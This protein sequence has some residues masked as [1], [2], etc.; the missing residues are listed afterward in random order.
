MSYFVTTLNS[1][2]NFLNFK[3]FLPQYWY[4]DLFSN[5]PANKYQQTISHIN[6]Y[7]YALM[8]IIKNGKLCYTTNLSFL[9]FRI[10]FILHSHNVLI[11][12]LIEM[13]PVHMRELNMSALRMKKIKYFFCH[14]HKNPQRALWLQVLFHISTGLDDL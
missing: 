3:I 6:Q 5:S 7:L 2:Y 8:E 12:I 4:L 11:F 9:Y 14:G 1:V 13:F 10:Y